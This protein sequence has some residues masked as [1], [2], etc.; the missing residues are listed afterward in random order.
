MS[1]G[2]NPCS[3]HDQGFAR[4][5]TRSNSMGSLTHHELIVN[6][7]TAKWIG[8][9]IPPALLKRADRVIQ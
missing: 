6:L 1:R 5:L 2:S 3:S 8:V 7:E 9:T 4:I